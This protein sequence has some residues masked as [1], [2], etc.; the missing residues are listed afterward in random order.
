MEKKTNQPLGQ[1]LN[2][3][4][5]SPLAWLGGKSRLAPTIIK[6]LPEHIAYVEVFAGA[7]WVLFT[8]PPSRVEII[9]DINGELVRF[10]RCVRLHLPELLKQFEWALIARDEWDAMLEQPV[11]GLTDIQRAAR[12]F[13]L[14]KMAY[15]AKLCNS[16]FGVAATG[17]PRLNLRDLPEL[18]EQTRLRLQRVVVENRPYGQV[19]DRFDKPG[20]LFYVDPPYWNCEDDYGKG[21][22]GRGDFALLAEQLAG[23]KGKCLISLNDTPG[24]RETFGRWPCFKFEEVATQYSVAARSVKP[25]V[26][27]LISNY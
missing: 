13:Y 12:F 22:F 27:L 9:N 3:K 26:E 17:L 15:G 10:Y 11:T 24:V 21:I 4:G 25:V 1:N 2:R 19:I 14:A 7:A 20:T 16:S 23:I 5:K 8:K 18:L 6:R